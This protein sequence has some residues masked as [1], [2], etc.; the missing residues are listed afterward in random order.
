MGCR[1]ELVEDPKNLNSRRIVLGPNLYF[2]ADGTRDEDPIHYWGS[3]VVYLIIF[4][5]Q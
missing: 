4:F 3:V 5:I 2:K 1:P